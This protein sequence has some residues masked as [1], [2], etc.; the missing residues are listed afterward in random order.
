VY[1]RS[2][3]I[4]RIYKSKSRVEIYKVLVHG[5][6]NKFLDENDIIHIYCN[7]DRRVLDE[8]IPVANWIMEEL[9]PTISKPGSVS[10]SILFETD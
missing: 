5:I 6:L 8:D 10:L 1:N 9:G 4:D 3:Y 2:R 7:A